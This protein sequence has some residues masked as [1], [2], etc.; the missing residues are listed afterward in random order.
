MKHDLIISQLYIQLA[1][2][3]EDIPPDSYSAN[4]VLE[5]AADYLM[6]AGYRLEDGEWLKD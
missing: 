6:D 1:A 5:E 2:A 3:L 4:M